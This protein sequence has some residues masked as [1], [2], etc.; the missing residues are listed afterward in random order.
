[1]GLNFGAIPTHKGAH[2]E[3]PTQNLH[4]TFRDESHPLTSIESCPVIYHRGESPL[5]TGLWETGTERPF[6]PF[7]GYTSPMTSG[8]INP[9][10]LGLILHVVRVFPS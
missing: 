10:P 1:M 9:N 5:E 2:L 4:L 3:S 8:K 7:Y 6:P